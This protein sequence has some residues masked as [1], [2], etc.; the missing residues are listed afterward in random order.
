MIT[1]T[2]T[3]PTTIS[4]ISSCDRKIYFVE[5]IDISPLYPP[6]ART[7]TLEPVS[8]RSRA[9]N[10][11]RKIV[12]PSEKKGHNTDSTQHSSDTPQPS[13]VSSAP[14]T[15]NHS[16]VTV[17]PAPSEIS[18]DSSQGQASQT[19]WQRKESPTTSDAEKANN[20]KASLTSKVIT[21]TVESQAGGCLRGDSIPVKVNISHTKHVKSLYGVI[22]TLYRLAR[23]DVRP[24]LPIGPTEK[25][26][27]VKYEDYYPKSMTG[28][29][30]LSLTGAGS[31]HVFRKDLSQVMSPLYVDPHTLTAELCPKVRVPE[32]AFP[33]IATVP[34]AMISF[35]Y[36]IEVVVDIQG[37]LSNQER[38]LSN[39]AGQATPTGHQL[40]FEGSDMDRSAF[41]PFGSTIVDT[42]PVRRDKS[43]V[44]CTFEVIIGTRD[45]ERRKG[46]RKMVDGVVELEVEQPQAQAQQESLEQPHT[47]QGGVDWYDASAYYGHGWYD[48]QH[49]YEYPPEPYHAESQEHSYDLPP[50]PPPVPIPQIPDES[51]LTEK[52]RIQR[53]EERLLPSQPPG[54]DGEEDATTAGA[55][56][57]YLPDESVDAS[58]P[59]QYPAVPE[60]VPP[61]SVIDENASS[62][63]VD[64]VD[65]AQQMPNVPEY[66][67]P[68]TESAPQ[69]VLVA[70]DDKQ[71]MQRQQL[72]AEAS[73]PPL[74]GDDEA[75]SSAVQ[76]PMPSAPTLDYAHAPVQD[77]H[78]SHADA[79]GSSE[80]PRYE[81]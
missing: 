10:H 22:V 53:A 5:R 24:S 27:D 62:V 46:K 14:S 45:S 25:G 51:Q 11:A 48:D 20:S 1:A 29:G 60:Y 69:A 34:G 56:A 54:M 40:N 26:K 41:T 42:A 68:Q 67:A 18:F 80:L 43:V 64:G 74:D 57:P 21:A 37:K 78:D 19:E 50:P 61:S 16:R 38:S 70:G 59:D 17:S 77:I 9:K 79:A 7:I 2:M 58:M 47:A 8:K 32:E 39:L 15:Q 65:C 72:Q 44:T 4:P 35:K 76:A 13:E 23:V 36:Y 28:L 66:S 31:S 30:G 75:G 71:E 73:A 81:R 33:T 3:R 55:T 52:E 63:V 12:D 49:P 6:K